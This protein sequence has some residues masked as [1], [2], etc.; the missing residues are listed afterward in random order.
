MD[1]MPTIDP[2]LSA[3]VWAIIFVLRGL[4]PSKIVN[5][6]GK[7][8]LWSMAVVASA[9]ALVGR[10]DLNDAVSLQDFATIILSI[11]TTAA[12]AVLTDG[13]AK[14]SGLSTTLRKAV[15]LGGRT[16]TP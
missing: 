9:I 7:E 4:V 15:T 13:A 6:D 2:A 16:N 1:F 10:G 12:G 3:G 14:M 11:A 8:V 5:I